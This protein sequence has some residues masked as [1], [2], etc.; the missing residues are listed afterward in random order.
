MLAKLPLHGPQIRL[1]CAP[2]WP[3]KKNATKKCK[4]SA[5]ET[6][7]TPKNAKKNC[8]LNKIL[9]ELP[10]MCTF[11]WGGLRKSSTSASFCIRFAICW[12]RNA[13][14][15]KKWQFF[16]LRSHG[17][18][19]KSGQNEDLLK[20]QKKNSSNLKIA[21]KIHT[22]TI[23]KKTP[24]QFLLRL[25]QLFKRFVFAIVQVVRLRTQQ[26]HCRFNCLSTCEFSSNAVQRNA[27]K[28]QNK[29]YFP[30]SL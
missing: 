22:Y 1:V 30:P 28:K 4:K 15:T 24:L 25:K 6:Q 27:L 7:E 29:M 9:E 23:A 14:T 17:L 3:S 16:C 18:E 13:K 10:W 20:N 21:G 26:L 11:C 19:G 2:E 5:K 12:P 8:V